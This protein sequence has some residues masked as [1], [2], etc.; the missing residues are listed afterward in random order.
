L[1]DIITEL[2]WLRKD[3]DNEAPIP[4]APTGA[5]V[6][7]VSPRIAPKTDKTRDMPAGNLRH[8]MHPDQ[9]TTVSRQIEGIPQTEGQIYQ[10]A[11][12]LRMRQK[13]QGKT[14]TKAPTAKE[15]VVLDDDPDAI[16]HN[17]VSLAY[18]DEADAKRI[19]AEKSG[20]RP[21]GPQRRAHSEDKTSNP[22][23]RP[24]GGAPFFGPRDRK[25]P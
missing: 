14:K 15:E 9:P 12:E 21:S 13:L 25:R 8:L 23:R 10:L 16:L 19:R 2:G 22:P 3:E 4:A 6:T 17:L 7:G 1:D 11:N 24:P 18:I 20:G 5:L